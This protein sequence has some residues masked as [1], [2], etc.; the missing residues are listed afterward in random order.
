MGPSAARIVVTCEE[1]MTRDRLSNIAPAGFTEAEKGIRWE[2]EDLEP[3]EDIHI[4][5]RR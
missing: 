5:V 1:G 3:T 2:F 4:L